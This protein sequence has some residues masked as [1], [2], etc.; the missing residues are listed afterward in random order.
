[1][2]LGVLDLL[3]CKWDKQPLRFYPAENEDSRERL[4]GLLVCRNYPTCDQVYLVTAGIVV[5][6]PDGLM[7]Q[8][9]RELLNQRLSAIRD[10]LELQVGSEK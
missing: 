4:E 10:K 7:D 5:A 3:V 2:D 6:L 1:M 8:S 9:D